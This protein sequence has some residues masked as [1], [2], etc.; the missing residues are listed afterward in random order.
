MAY[1]LT[2]PDTALEI[3]VEADLVAT[4]ETQGWK[5]KPTAKRRPPSRTTSNTHH[6]RRAGTTPAAMP[7]T[8]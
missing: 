8:T 1:K 6:R 2:H 4:Y 3:S 5:T 7:H